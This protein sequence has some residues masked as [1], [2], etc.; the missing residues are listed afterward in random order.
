[1]DTAPEAE[2]EAE[3]REDCAAEE[4]DGEL[5]RADDDDDEEMMAGHTVSV[6]TLVTE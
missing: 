6:D 3:E 4:A 1:M 5:G 2:A